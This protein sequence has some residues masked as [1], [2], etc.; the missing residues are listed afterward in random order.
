MDVREALRK[1]EAL[2]E[3]YGLLERLLETGRACP[4]EEA[5]PGAERA[6]AL[7]E[8]QRE[9]MLALAWIGRRETARWLEY[10]RDVMDRRLAGIRDALQTGP[11]GRAENAKAGMEAEWT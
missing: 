9:T 3:G 4:A 2:A 5:L 11:A 7:E 1:F 6:P 10:T 8:P